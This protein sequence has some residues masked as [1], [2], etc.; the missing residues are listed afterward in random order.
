MTKDELRKAIFTKQ[1]LRE[2]NGVHPPLFTA[3]VR[4]KIHRISDYILEQTSFEDGM[5]I[6]RSDLESIQDLQTTIVIDGQVVSVDP[7]EADLVDDLRHLISD[8]WD[9]TTEKNKIG[10]S[11]EYTFKARRIL[12]QIAKGSVTADDILDAEKII[13]HHKIQLTRIYEN[14]TGIPAL[15]IQDIRETRFQ[16]GQLSSSSRIER[17]LEEASNFT[18]H[19]YLYLDPKGIAIHVSGGSP[20]PLVEYRRSNEDNEL[21]RNFYA[22]QPRYLPNRIRENGNYKSLLF[23]P[24]PEVATDLIRIVETYYPGALVE[25]SVYM[26]ASTNDETPNGPTFRF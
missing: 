21:F 20:T 9:F 15:E 7:F 23:P 5:V 8:D 3:V 17:S 13:V 18:K 22:E 19:T 10:L 6:I 25:H 24:S 26:L 11:K 1:S 14:Y 16:S 2:L 4:S 12:A